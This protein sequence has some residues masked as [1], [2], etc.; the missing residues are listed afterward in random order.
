MTELT[1]YNAIYKAIEE[2]ESD[3]KRI[4]ERMK[5]SPNGH[6]FSDDIY[7]VKLSQLSPNEL[8]DRITEINARL[9]LSQEQIIEKEEGENA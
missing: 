8:L 1:D 7:E 9:A 5:R 2:M 6:L 3:L 4:V